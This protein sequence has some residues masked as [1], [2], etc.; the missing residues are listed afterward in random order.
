MQA[1]WVSISAVESLRDKGGAGGS[2]PVDSVRSDVR[3]HNGVTVD[4]KRDTQIALDHDRI[5]G[6]AKDG[7][8]PVYFVDSQPRIEGIDFE[9]S[10]S[11]AHRFPLPARQFS[12]VAPELR[13]RDVTV[14][15]QAGG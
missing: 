4:V 11:P 10:P 6:P 2:W 12:E 13:L 14:G 3:G 15:F 7:G 1:D 5:D 8:K 9:D